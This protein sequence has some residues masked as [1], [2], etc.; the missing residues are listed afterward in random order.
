MEMWNRGGGGFT[1]AVLSHHRTYGSVYGGSGYTAKPVY[2]IKYRDQPDPRPCHAA[3]FSIQR[4]FQMLPQEPLD[5]GHHSLVFDLSFDVGH[6]DI[7]VDPIKELLQIEF[8]V[9]AVSRRHM[10]AGGFD[11]L[12]SASAR[13]KAV[14]VVRKVSRHPRILSGTRSNSLLWEKFLHFGIQRDSDAYW[15]HNLFGPW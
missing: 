1:S 4:Q 12:M 2:R 6:Q 5:A 10:G 7:V 13:T 11:G 8:H 15:R 9:P 3:L 14:A